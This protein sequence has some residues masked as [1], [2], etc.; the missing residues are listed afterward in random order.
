MKRFKTGTLIRIKIFQHWKF[1]M[2]LSKDAQKLVCKDCGKR[3]NS[4]DISC[5]EDSYFLYFF[6][7]G[8]DLKTFCY[9]KRHLE[10]DLKRKTL[11]I[12]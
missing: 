12:L 4:T 10:A 2:V 9:R 7:S 5:Q 11:A 6:H 8:M 3:I 1:A